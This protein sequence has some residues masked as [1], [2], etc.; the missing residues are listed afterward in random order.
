[1]AWDSQ[2]LSCA[3]ART[4]TVAKYFGAFGAGFPRGASN[5]AASTEGR[6]S[7]KKKEQKENE[8]PSPVVDKLVPDDEAV[9]GS[10]SPI[11]LPTTGCCSLYKLVALICITSVELAAVDTRK[12]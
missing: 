9:E 5:L 8:E 6:C 1:V 4:S 12:Q 11:G 10:Y 2:S 3:A 7:Q